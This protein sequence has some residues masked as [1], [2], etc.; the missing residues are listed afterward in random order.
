VYDIKWHIH[1]NARAT[2]GW[3]RTMQDARE[4]EKEKKRKRKRDSTLPNA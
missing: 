2:P 3:H 1:G 4:K